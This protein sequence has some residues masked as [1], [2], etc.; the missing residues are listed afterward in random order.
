MKLRQYF[1]HNSPIWIYAILATAWYCVRPGVDATVLIPVDN[2]VLKIINLTASESY[3]VPDRHMIRRFS[4]TVRN[5]KY[6]R[7]TQDGSLSIEENDLVVDVGAFI[8]EFAVP[9]A[10]ECNKLIAFE[11]SHVNYQCL[12]KN[13]SSHTNIYCYQTALSDSDE[14]DV[15]FKIGDDPTENSLL[16]VDDGDTK[17]IVDTNTYRLDSITNGLNVEAIN[18]LKIDAEGLEP[19]VLNGTKSVPVEKIAVDTGPERNGETTTAQVKHILN[20]HGFRTQV[21]QPI[22]YGYD[23]SFNLK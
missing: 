17:R 12:V 1:K 15:E 23:P 18:F 6:S 21:E 11:P 13:T 4:K 2:G 22:V 19:E 7:F 3:F 8:G 9:A 16:Q 10:K 20:E 14:V 5:K